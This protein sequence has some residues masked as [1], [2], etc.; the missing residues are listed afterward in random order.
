MKCVAYLLDIVAWKSFANKYAEY[1]IGGPTLEL[2]VNSY[3]TISDNLGGC[4][5]APKIE[6][7]VKDGTFNSGSSTASMSAQYGYTCRIAG[8]SWAD[9]INNAISTSNELYIFSSS[10]ADGFYLASVTAGGYHASNS[11]I[12]IDYTGSLHSS[13]GYR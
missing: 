8:E 6:I 10:N 3:N 5:K 9:Y 13:S 12:V 1:A 11:P 7:Q 4:S 2:F